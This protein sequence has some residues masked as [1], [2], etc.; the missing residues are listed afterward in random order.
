[1]RV[2]HE[3]LRKFECPDAGC[4]KTFGYK[5]VMQRHLER[6]HRPQN[7]ES[8]LPKPNSKPTNQKNTAKAGTLIGLLTGQDY[9][10]SPQSSKS[11][12]PP[13]PR[14]ISCPWPSAFGTTKLVNEP[15]S[16]TID[17][18]VNAHGLEAGADEVNAWVLKY[19]Q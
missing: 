6:H 13:R 5:H 7:N 15:A 16:S 11:N 4:D 10:E 3:G 14:L 18:L 17:N 12:A 19:K 1:M 9:D 2:S 8:A